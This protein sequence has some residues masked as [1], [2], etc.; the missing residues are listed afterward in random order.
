MPDF[1]LATGHTS[2]EECS[3]TY[4]GRHLTLEENLLNHPTHGDGLVNGGDPIVDA[5]GENI[6]GVAF[7]SAAANTDPISIDTEGI[8]FLTA[9]A[10]DDWGNNPIQYGD[11]IFISLANPVLSKFRNKNTHQHFGYALG[12]VATGT[13]A[14]VAIKVHWDPDDAEEIV[15]KGTAFYELGALVANGREYRYRSNLAQGDSRGMYMALGL[16]GGAS[17]EAVRARTIVETV[18]IGG[19]VHGLHGGVE[20]DADGTIT[21]LGVGVRG[22]FMCPDRVMGGTYFGGMSELWAEGTSSDMSGFNAIHN[23]NMGGDGTGIATADYVW[24]FTNLSAT[25]DQAH[26][27][28]V[29]GLTRSLQVILDGTVYYVGLSNAP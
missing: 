20:F 27:A 8:W 21:G 25:Q 23:F 29:A 10:T 2:G 19:G 7:I 4:E 22:T 17:G 18:G 16:F 26:N 5:G 6:V 1:Y 11:E 12:T 15:G 14:V 13:S 24:S 3:S 28:W 9:T